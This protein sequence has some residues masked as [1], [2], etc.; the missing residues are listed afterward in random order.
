MRRHPPRMIEL[1]EVD[2]QYLQQVIRDGH[3]AQRVACRARILMAMTDPMTVVQELAEHLEVVRR[4]IW[5][6]CRR[7]EAVGVEALDDAS[8]SGRPREFSPCSV[9]RS[10]NW[11]AVLRRALACT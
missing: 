2:R 11:P 10:N 9:L 3:A 1:T 7:Y 4:T 5:N 6:V 8:R